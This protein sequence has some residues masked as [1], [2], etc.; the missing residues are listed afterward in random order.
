[1]LK[2]SKEH[3][4]RR[5]ATAAFAFAF[6]FALIVTGL[7]PSVA[8]AHGP[9]SPVASS[10]LAR[11]T[12]VPPGLQTKVIDGDQR[13]WL[14]VSGGRTVIVLDYHGAPYLRFT[15]GGSD[16]N[17]DSALYYLNQTPAEVPPAGLTRDTRPRWAR[18]S[19]ARDYN[20]H[21][22]RLHA[23]AGV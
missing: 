16:V 18:V 9:V 11:A 3:I 21:D 15:P 7:W 10:F 23:L 14:K 1:M 8:L 2:Q 22:G 4:A 6:A 19:S 20:C 13:M 12:A 17:H 5:T